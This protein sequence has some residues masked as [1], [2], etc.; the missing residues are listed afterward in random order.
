MPPLQS[1]FFTGKPC[2]KIGLP[3]FTSGKLES[4]NRL[5]GGAIEWVL[6]GEPGFRYLIEKRLPP[7][8]WEPLTVLTNDTGRVT[9]TDPDQ[10]NSSLKFYRSRMLE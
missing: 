9:F 3:E 1:P 2:G 4:G 5:L 10:Q 7:Q 6:T 8:N